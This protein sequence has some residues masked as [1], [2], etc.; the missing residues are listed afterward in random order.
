MAKHRTP[1]QI[2]HL[3]RQ[4]EVELAGGQSVPQAC[5]K[6]GVSEQTYYR[7]RKEYG[8]IR[9]DQAKRLKELERENARLKRLV[10]EAELDKAILREAAGGKLLSPA[11]RTAAVEHV[12]DALGRGVVSERRACRVLGQPRSTQ[13]R[14]AHVPSDEPALVRRMVELATE[15]GRYGYRR[16]AA[17]LRA[18]GFAVNHKRVERLWRREGLKVPKR[19]PKRRRLWLDDGSCVRLRPAHPNHVWSYDFV[20]ARTADGR[21]FRLL[22]VIDEHTRECLAIDVARRITADD[23]L[24][25]LCDLFADRGPPEHLRSDNGPEFTARA[26]RGWLGTVGVQT[27]FIAPGSPWENGYVESF[28]GK[29]RDELLNPELFD[30]LLEAKVL[31]ERWRRGYNGVRPHSALGY[32]PPAPEVVLVP[33]PEPAAAG[34]SDSGP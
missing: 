22:T 28:N 3:L 1:E 15:Y 25:R 4:A 21:A 31:T 27:L 29:V 2:I 6:L 10:A 5:R 33:P 16:V 13:R 23:V 14:E 7:W 18:E 32:R 24:H 8:G 11:K 12:R 19:Q 17:L 34:R 30:T 9:T 20:T 26:V